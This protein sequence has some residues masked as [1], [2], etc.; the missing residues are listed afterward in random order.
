M[1]TITFNLS[2]Y[3]HIF[4]SAQPLNNLLKTEK[5]AW[6]LFLLFYRS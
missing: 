2:L 5:N 1:D 4:I 6:G 3:T